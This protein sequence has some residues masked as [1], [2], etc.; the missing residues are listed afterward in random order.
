MV[1]TEWTCQRRK[2]HASYVLDP[3]IATGTAGAVGFGCGGFVR[4]SEHL[5]RPHSFI[6]PYWLERCVSL[7]VSVT[8]TAVMMRLNYDKLSGVAKVAAAFGANLRVNVYQ[9]SKTDR[10]SVSYD[11]FWLGFKQLAESTRLVATTE[12]VLAVE[13][14][15]WGRLEG[16]AMQ[17]VH[18]VCCGVVH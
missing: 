11:Q 7:G 4:S 17:V 5:R 1:E 10:F 13:P 2:N 16:E 6:L 3:I 15:S 12:P 8:V 9:P 18:P 14:G